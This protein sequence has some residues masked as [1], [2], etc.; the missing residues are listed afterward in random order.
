MRGKQLPPRLLKSPAFRGYS[1]NVITDFPCVN[2][3]S[4]MPSSWAMSVRDSAG[5]LNPNTRAT[6]A[7]VEYGPKTQTRSHAPSAA[8]SRSTRCPLDADSCAVTDDDVG[9]LQPHSAASVRISGPMHLCGDLGSKAPSRFV[10]DGH[11]KRNLP[12][13]ACGHPLA[14]DQAEKRSSS[15]GLSRS[16]LS[17]VSGTW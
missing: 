11:Q 10:A 6:S 8:D 1:T 9:S 12:G 17:Q 7:S 13:A 14:A 16:K 3:S 15:K 5:Q 2:I 4:E